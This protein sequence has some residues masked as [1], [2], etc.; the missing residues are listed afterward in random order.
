MTTVDVPGATLYYETRGTGPLL[1]LVSGASGVADSFRPLAEELAE[2]R[3]VL[4]YDRRGFS[5]S[6]LNCPQDHGSRL[7]TDA[8]DVRRLIEHAASG[9]ADV[10]G[11]SSGAIVALAAL[12][13]HPSAVRTVIAYEPPLLRLLPAGAGWAEFFADLYQRYRRTGVEPALT[14]FRERTFAASDRQIMARAPRNDANAAHW[15]EHE[16]RQYPLADLDLVALGDLADRVIPAVGWDGAGYPAHDATVELGR[17]LDRRVVR[18]PGG[19]LGFLGHPAEFAREVLQALD[20]GA[21]AHS[22]APSATEWDGAYAGSPHW[23]LGRPQP[24][25]Q[26]LADT[27]ALRGRVLDVGCG[28][29]EHVLMAAALRLDATGIDLA[30]TALDTASRRARDRGLTARFLRHDV[31]RLRELAETFD[32][33]LDCGLFHILDEDDRT[34]YL[35]GVRAVLRLGGRYLMLCFSDRQP[36]HGGPRRFTEPELRSRFAD[37]WHLDALDATTLDS[38]HDPAGV[39]GWLVTATRT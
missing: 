13:D 33:V 24:A 37:G 25:F 20:G 26:A 35:D 32:T 39:H 10:L 29:G 5:R 7:A 19:H 21:A 34:A 11:S 12:A 15:F 27:G 4:T 38:P 6:R 36:G 9:P 1:V 30:P 17:R 3:T 18:L 14:E 28:T 16:L 23:D 2:R 8:G 22:P 31:L